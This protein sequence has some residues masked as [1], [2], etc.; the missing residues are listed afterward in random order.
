MAKC[1]NGRREGKNAGEKRASG[2]D[3]ASWV[4]IFCFLSSDRLQEWFREEVGDWKTLMDR[5]RLRGAEPPMDEMID[6]W[7]NGRKNGSLFGEK[8]GGEAKTINII[9]R[10][11]TAK[12]AL[13][14][15]SSLF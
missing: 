1:E 5:Y 2:L 7:L 13:N 3:N 8:G 15:V 4:A 14:A 12:M 9:D 10:A 11:M 6:I